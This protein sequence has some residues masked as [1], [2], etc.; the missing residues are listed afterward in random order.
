MHI[1]IEKKVL[2]EAI[3]KL[4]ARNHTGKA[5]KAYLTSSVVIS[6]ADKTAILQLNTAKV[7]VAAVG[8]WEGL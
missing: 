5:K 7:T 3:K 6:L 4:E 2:L 8:T 1:K